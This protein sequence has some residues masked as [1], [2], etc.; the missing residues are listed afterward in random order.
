M[1]SHSLGE[2][3]TKRSKTNVSCSAAS[4]GAGHGV[5]GQRQAEGERCGWVP[6]AKRILP[7]H[8]SP[9]ATAEGPRAKTSTGPGLAAR[10]VPNGA[11]S[12]GSQHQPA[13]TSDPRGSPGW[14]PRVPP[15]RREQSRPCA[16]FRWDVGNVVSTRLGKECSVY[17]TMT[18]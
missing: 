14:P 7:K 13:R 10:R 17:K 6:A 3:G 8:S 12:G 16:A 5:G 9:E 11:F 15:L 2:E 4:P 1:V 18:F